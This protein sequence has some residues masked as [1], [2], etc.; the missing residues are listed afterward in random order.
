MTEN[1]KALFAFVLCA[2]YVVWVARLLWRYYAPKWQKRHFEQDTVLIA[3]AS[4]TGTARR[5]AEKKAATIGKKQNV[6]LLS[7]ADLSV[8][9]LSNVSKAWFIVSTYGNGEPPDSGRKFARDIQNQQLPPTLLQRL[10]YGVI[11]L[12][13]SRYPHFC[14]FGENLYDWLKNFGAIPFQAIERVDQSNPHRSDVT[15]VN[16]CRI[17]NREQLNQG[18][19]REL[20]MVEL[21]PVDEPCTWE[22]GDIV[23][24]EPQNSLQDIQ[25]WLGAHQLDGEL[26]MS[27]STN[28]TLAT[29]I[30][31]RQLHKLD[32]NR[33]V[34]EQVLNLP[35]LPVRSYSIASVEQE[36]THSNPHIKLIVRK[37]YREDGHP[38]LG[39][40][41]LTTFATSEDMFAVHIKPNAS[42]HIA[43]DEA[44][45]ILIGAG[46]GIAGI[47]AQAFKR[48]MS[49]SR[50]AIWIMYGERSP[51]EDNVIDKLLPDTLK[52]DKRLRIDTV[53]SRGD[54]PAYV[55]TLLLRH[56]QNIQQMV[57]AGAHIYVCGSY[58]G[59]GQDVHQALID[60]LSADNIQQLIDTH[61]YH[62]DVY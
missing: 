8:S 54:R 11:A 13:D 56:A 43:I 3:Y 12:G 46:S 41:W 21:A 18:K 14:A 45:I 28:Q 24:I 1:Q 6:T 62:R 25:R 53:Y 19:G 42:C 49:N 32:T 9:N 27:G 39:S 40:G 5:L 50:A 58:Q 10:E 37:Q 47:R 61:R 55:Q 48:L 52:H 29:L 30:K 59:M 26:P 38:G 31:H 33:D 60:V 17:V 7:L 4:Q 20:F 16:Q 57:E 44:P 36:P 22:A 15:E 2:I 34:Q 35:Y 51:S 23:D